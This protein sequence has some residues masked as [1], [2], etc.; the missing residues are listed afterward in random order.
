MTDTIIENITYARNLKEKYEY[1][2]AGLNFTLLAAAIK[3]AELSNSNFQR[4]LEIGGLALLLISGFLLIKRFESQPVLHNAYAH[5]QALERDIRSATTAQ[6]A[7]QFD[8]QMEDTGRVLGIDEYI[9]KLN[10]AKNRH[11]K[12]RTNLEGIARKLYGFHKWLFIFAILSLMISRLVV[13]W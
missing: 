13:I 5:L 1:F 2:L 6:E 11:E 8:I 3:T 9:S 7:G 10:D 12:Q 4:A